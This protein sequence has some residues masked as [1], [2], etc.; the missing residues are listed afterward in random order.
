MRVPELL[1]TMSASRAWKSGVADAVQEAIVVDL[2]GRKRLR[3]ADA[4]NLLQQCIGAQVVNLSD[5]RGIGDATVLVVAARCGHL[6]ELNVTGCPN[7]TA[8]SLDAVVQRCP[9][10]QSLCL[11][12]CDRVPE[13]IIVQRF[14]RFCDIFD[15]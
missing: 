12:G 7:I 10:L 5:C 8:S 2:R 3:D 1:C 6:V 4:E 14:A 9:N 13:H 15:E 11:A